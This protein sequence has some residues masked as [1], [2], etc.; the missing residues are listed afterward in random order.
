MSVNTMSHTQSEL[1]VIT[2]AKNLLSY[3]MMIAQKSPQAVSLFADWTYAGICAG[4]CRGN[5]LRQRY[6]RYACQ[7]S[8]LGES[9]GTSAKGDARAEAAGVC[10]AGQHGVGRHSAQVV[11]T[12]QQAGV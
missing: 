3:V 2:F 6:I 4:Y 8:W 5:V 10:S 9:A 11:R 7:P 1:Q 12:D